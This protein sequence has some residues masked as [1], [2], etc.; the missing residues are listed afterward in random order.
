[1]S[2]SSGSVHGSGG[3]LSRLS[4]QSGARLRQ[5]A[6]KRCATEADVSWAMRRLQFDS[7]APPQSQANGAATDSQKGQIDSTEWLQDAP[8]WLREAQRQ[9]DALET[10]SDPAS[11]SPPQKVSTA[12]ARRERVRALELQA[13]LLLQR[14]WKLQRRRRLIQ[15]LRLRAQR[16]GAAR[17]RLAAREA[18]RLRSVPP[19]P[20]APRSCSRIRYAVV[21]ESTPPR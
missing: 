3:R 16:V 2:P 4:T 11:S 13:T 1:M 19:P 10:G 8:A 5:R 7:P 17:V 9:V 20:C 12:S 18:G 15:M 6:V 14:W 21:L